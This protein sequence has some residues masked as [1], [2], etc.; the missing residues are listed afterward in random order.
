MSL[1]IITNDRHICKHWW[2]SFRSTKS[3]FHNDYLF[4]YKTLA[5]YVHALIYWCGNF[6]WRN[7]RVRQLHQVSPTHRYGWAA[8]PLN[9]NS[10]HF[11]LIDL[12]IEEINKTSTQ[13]LYLAYRYLFYS[14]MVPKINQLSRTGQGNF[15]TIQH[16]LK[17]TIRLF[18]YKICKLATPFALTI[19]LRIC[20]H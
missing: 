19:L 14:P 6:I 5:Y 2:F 12:H 10:R 18:L 1:D 4:R 17:V 11:N 3:T 16:R 15:C 8:L 9:L 20:I 7:S 13:Y